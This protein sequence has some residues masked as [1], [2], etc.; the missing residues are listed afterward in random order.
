M[1]GHKVFTHTHTHAHAHA[2]SHTHAHTFTPLHILNNQPNTQRNRTLSSSSLRSS[3]RTGSSASGG[4]RTSCRCGVYV[5]VCV[6]ARVCVCLCA[7]VRVSVCGSFV[8]VL[9]GGGGF[10]GLGH[11]GWVSHTTQ[12]RSFYR[13]R[14]LISAEVQNVMSDGTVHL[15]TRTVRYGT[16]TILCLFV[17]WCIS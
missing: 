11:W 7:C 13:E 2:H 6:R 14:D 8:V 4:T 12:N 5:S 17:L 16:E 1:G 9:L 15:H 3:C 10:R